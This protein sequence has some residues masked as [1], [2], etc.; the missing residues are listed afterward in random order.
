MSSKDRPL[1]NHVSKIAHDRS[2]QADTVNTQGHHRRLNNR[3]VQLITIGASIGTALFVGIG[4]GLAAGGSASLPITCSLY[5]MLLTCVNNCIAEMT[6]HR[7]ASSG[8]IR[9]A[10]MW[11]D[12]G[13]GFMAGWNFLF[14]GALMVLVP[15]D[16]TLSL[17]STGPLLLRAR[18]E[19]LRATRSIVQP[20]LRRPAPRE[21]RKNLA[22]ALVPLGKLLRG[23]GVGAL[24]H[25]EAREQRRPLHRA[26]ANVEGPADDGAVLVGV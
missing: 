6:I 20:D 22:A 15:T 12:N 24:A 19:R 17:V 11:Y 18:R 13:F 2:G 25:V 21:P 16:P 23:D 14:S 7:S 5:S 3:Q 1:A 8:F 26:A 4:N 9:L 10:G